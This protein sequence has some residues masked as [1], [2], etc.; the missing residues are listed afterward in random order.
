[1]CVCV[2]VCVCVHVYFESFWLIFVEVYLNVSTV[3][4]DERVKVYMYVVIKVH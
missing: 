4:I 3:Y 1:M 2:C